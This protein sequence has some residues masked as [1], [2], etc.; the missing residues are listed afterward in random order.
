MNL[1][2]NNT[3]PAQR[4]LEALFFLMSIGVLLAL[5]SKPN[6]YLY[7]DAYISFRYAEHLAAG[8]GLVWNIGGEPTQGYTNFLFVLLSALGVKLGLAVETSAHLLNGFGILLIQFSFY[9]I[10]VRL[11]KQS[12][13]RGLPGLA[14]A[15]APLSLQ[16]A[17]TGMETIFWAGLVAAATATLIALLQGVQRPRLWLI[18][19]GLLS[20][21]GCLTRPESVLFA[22]LW[23]LL[24]FVGMR[25]HRRA[26]IFLGVVFALLGGLYLLWLHSYFGAILPN[27]FYVKV[28]DSELL[29]GR[30]YISDF[31]GQELLFLLPLAPLALGLLALPRWTA[32]QLLLS[33]GVVL[34]LLIFY[35]FA[36]PLMGLYHRFVYPVYGFAWLL[37]GV[38]GGAIYAWLVS[39]K[40]LAWL[41]RFQSVPLLAALTALL[42]VASQFAATSTT[43]IGALFRANERVGLALSQVPNAGQIMVAYN[44]VGILPFVSD[45]QN[46]DTVGLNNNAIA[47][48]GKQEGWLWV[49]GYVLGTRPDVIGFYTFP[50]GVV[51]N[52]GHGVIGG[53]YSV[54]AT[55][56]DF[57]ANYTFA[58]GYNADWVHTQ[59]YVYNGSAHFEA[60]RQALAAAADFDT[61]TVR[62]P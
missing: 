49:V 22:G 12:W 51:Y 56:N 7:D 15:I 52:Y 19:H 26:V 34:T 20:F 16:N 4:T 27:S 13:W 1:T 55:A 24:L 61:Y 37:I 9:N 32:L 39:K 14:V 18:G 43:D 21:A 40:G 8:H 3:N 60:L 54:L 41:G 2:K 50:D 47:R 42:I 28:G 44:D 38:G 46:L 48:K 57:S 5:H 30:G 6:G 35:L 10:A 45:T 53:Y 31:F 11:L 23:L 29:P 62:V 36:M 58:G 17:L 33:G 25:G 59:W